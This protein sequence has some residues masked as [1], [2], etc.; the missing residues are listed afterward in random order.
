MNI[1]VRISSRERLVLTAIIENYIATG[2]PV[3]SQA[4]AL[5]LGNKEGLSSATIRNVMA[6]LADQGLLDQ[7]HSSAGR[8]PTPQ[9]FRYY[10]DQLALSSSA[11]PGG[12]EGLTQERRDLIEESFAGVSSRQQFLER[13]SHVL[14]L[15]SNGVGVAIASTS[16]IHALEHIHF[17]RLTAGRVLA[18]VVTRAGVVLDRVLMLD[19]DL[20]AGELEAAAQ[21]LNQSF[22]GWSIERIRGELSHRIEQERS[23]YNR[24]MQ[25]VTQLCLNGAFDPSIGTQAI[26]VEGVGNLIGGEADGERLRQLLGAL[27]AKQ[28]L[29]ELLNAY[30]D[31]RQQSV[32]VVVGLEDAMPEMRNLVLIG[33]PA[34]LG[35]ESVGSLAVIGP[36]RIQYQDTMNV[37]SFIAQLSER[38]LQPVQ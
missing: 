10:V 35:T 16:E 6:S 29:I 24:L 4:I 13:T 22:H 3:A 25:S 30:V 1:P 2:E 34:L 21:F 28:R 14:A 33:A 26:F 5:R 11:A 27:E 20:S 19:H 23:E 12:G 8:I 7:P 15:I 32:R 38:I 36:T 17:S 9:A 18:V 37:V 31:A